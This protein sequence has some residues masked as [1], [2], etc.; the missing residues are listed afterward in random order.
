MEL[1][2][3]CDQASQRIFI[4]FSSQSLQASSSDRASSR[5]KETCHIGI[6]RNNIKARWHKQ[7]YGYKY[8]Y[9]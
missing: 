9:Q 6:S 8:C 2:K 5:G 1:I 7:T 4:Y 3:L